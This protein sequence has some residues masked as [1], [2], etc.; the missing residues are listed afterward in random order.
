MQTRDRADS[1]Q[2]GPHKA[3][4]IAVSATRQEK[5]EIMDEK[6]TVDELRSLMRQVHLPGAVRE[7]VLEAAHP[8]V[9]EPTGASTKRRQLITRRSA[10]R[11]G[12]AAAS[13][14]AT[15]VGLS[16]HGV[17]HKGEQAPKEAGSGS[18]V[19]VAYAEGTRQDDEVILSVDDFGTKSSS[20]SEGD[21]GSLG[22]SHSLSLNCTGNAIKKLAYSLEGTFA[23]LPQDDETSRSYVFFDAIAKGPLHEY[24][25]ADAGS[26]CTN[27]TLAYDQL[28]QDKESFGRSVRAHFPASAELT[29]ALQSFKQYDPTREDSRSP[30]AIRAY[31]EANRTVALYSEKT[32]AELLSQ[33]PLVIT[34]TFEDDSTKTKRYVIAPITDFERVYGDWLERLTELEV[35][36]ELGSDDDQVARDEAEARYVEQ[37]SAQPQLYTIREEA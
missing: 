35:K 3:K 29:S 22:V 12:L 11:L 17:P 37:L 36:M 13:V 21:E 9:A 14:A 32:Y 16:M 15:F 6:R 31:C 5:G 4:G 34:A 19:L 8:D 2:T 18:F 20:W 24:G 30:D 27:F 26:S 28:A 33:T 25:E 23:C 1:P 7:N 10:L